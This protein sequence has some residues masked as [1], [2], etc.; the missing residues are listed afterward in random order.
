MLGIFDSGAGG[1]IAYRDVR[2]ALPHEDIVYLADRGN[3]PYGTK[4]KDE[5]IRLVTN[6]IMRLRS[7]GCDK[8]LIACCTASTVYP[9]IP[10]ELWDGVIPIISPTAL[11][12]RGGRRISV[13]ATRH[14]VR[15]SAFSRALHEISDSCYVSEIEAGELVTLV[16]E[17][18][19]DGYLDINQKITVEN[20]VKKIKAQDPDTLILGCTHFSHLE[21]SFGEHLPNV[22]IVSSAREGAKA[23]I[24]LVNP[25]RESGISRYT[26]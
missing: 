8:I 6:D 11:A 1:L 10:R 25:R 15:D 26:E 19:R 14:T 21:A 16:E 17:G 20:I 13:I 2:A 12:A 3:A 18:G 23:L 4:D 9:H 24:R 7:Y 22:R 5:L